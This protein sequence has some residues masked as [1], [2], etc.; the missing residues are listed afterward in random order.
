MQIDVASQNRYCRPDYQN[1]RQT[2]PKYDP[3]TVALV[4][5]HR[6]LASNMLLVDQRNCTGPPSFATWFDFSRLPFGRDRLDQPERLAVKLSCNEDQSEHLQIFG[7]GQ[8]ALAISNYLFVGWMAWKI[9]M[10]SSWR[11]PT[12]CSVAFLQGPIFVIS[13]CCT[14]EIEIS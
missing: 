11:Q 8:V 12:V 14:P 5:R 7:H 10:G 9:L 4:D 3:T 13:V 2:V 1:N 6:F